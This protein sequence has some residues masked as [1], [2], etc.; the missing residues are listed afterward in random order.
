MKVV[1]TNLI[2]LFF[3]LG[4]SVLEPNL[5]LKKED[6]NVSKKVSKNIEVEEVK[7]K[8]VSIVS[9]IP[10]EE[11]LENNNLEEG[12]IILNVFDDELYFEKDKVGIDKTK[13]VIKYLDAFDWE[14]KALQ[15]IYKKHK[16][17]W[18]QKQSEDFQKILIED[19][20]LSL[21][22]DRR[23][24]DNLEFEESQPEQDILQ[25]I[26]LIK[27]LNNLSHGCPQW[28]ESNCKVK[29]ENAKERI[30]IK[31][32]FSLLPHGVIIEKLFSLYTPKEKKFRT[33]LKKHKNSL[34]L[35]KKKEVLRLERLEIE[36]FKCRPY[37]P[38]YEKKRK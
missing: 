8:N 29:N 37:D 4:C 23:Y 5:D 32:V 10:N 6:N 2:A 34:E 30:N 1:L 7:E 36:A 31:Q 22:G 12:N 28:V 25:S 15:K 3:F 18:S 9:T 14:K 24:W 38:S 35:A 16:R 27:Y 19:K 33:L 13:V 17:L 11:I 21:C 20:Y 26:L